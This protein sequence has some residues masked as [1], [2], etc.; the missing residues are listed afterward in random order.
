MNPHRIREEAADAEE[1]GADLAAKCLREAADEIERLLAALVSI[2]I[3]N[4][5]GGR[6]DPEIDKIVREVA[7][8]K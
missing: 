2:G 8:D 4:A 6:P 3:L 5:S 7:G 1:Y